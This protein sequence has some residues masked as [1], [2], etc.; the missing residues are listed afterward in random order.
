MWGKKSFGS[1][2]QPPL[3]MTKNGGSGCDGCPYLVMSQ[4]VSE[5]E[6]GIATLLVRLAF[7]Y[8]SICLQPFQFNPLF[9]FLSSVSSRSDSK[10]HLCPPSLTYSELTS[11][12]P[13]GLCFLASFYFSSPYLPLDRHHFSLS[14]FSFKKGFQH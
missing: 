3:R 14:F 7:H 8:L 4:T 10:I 2:I 9:S 13:L 5:R 6:H 11:L 1:V 12:A